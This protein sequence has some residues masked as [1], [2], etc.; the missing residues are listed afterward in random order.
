MN[1][2]EKVWTTYDANDRNDVTSCSNIGGKEYDDRFIIIKG[3]KIN[4][5]DFYK[6]NDID[7]YYITDELKNLP[8]YLYGRVL[9]GLD[10]NG[11]NIN[12][13]RMMEI[14]E[15][16]NT[17]GKAI[18]IKVYYKGKLVGADYCDEDSDTYDYVFYAKDIKRGMTKKQVK[19]LYWWGSPDESS[20]Y[21][22][23]KHTWT[24][25]TYEDESWIEFKDGKARAWYDAAR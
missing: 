2:S 3:F 4:K 19:N 6:N 7:D 1:Y 25:W 15:N 21:S 24:Y 14:Q 10:Y 20:S 18:K 12:Y 23:G 17:Y 5:T 9:F 11:E 13:E 8:V 16:V 22:D